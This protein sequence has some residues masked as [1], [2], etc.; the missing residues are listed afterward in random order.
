[1]DIFSNLTPKQALFCHEYF[2]DFN[3]T[4]AA[5]RAGY[6][7]AT[8]L[9]GHLMTL[10]KI[11]FHLQQRG[12]EA[13]ERAQVTHQMVLA[14]L[15]KVAF[16]GMGDFFDDNGNLLPMHKVKAEA[17]SAV[18][19]YTVTEAK[20]GTTTIKIRMNNKLSA[21]DKIAKHLKFY[22]AEAPTN[23]VNYWIQEQP[24]LDVDD[25][26]DDD[27]FAKR[28]T[29]QEAEL[30]RRVAE[31]TQQAIA[32]TERRMKKHFAAKL[33][34]AKNASQKKQKNT[35]KYPP[36]C[37][38]GEHKQAV[39]DIIINPVVATEKGN[40]DETGNDGMEITKPLTD[41]TNN[42]AAENEAKQIGQQQS[43]YIPIGEPIGYRL[44]LQRNRTR[45]KQARYPGMDW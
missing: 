17:R 31:A 42:T 15:K 35:D 1:M 33:K 2:K 34:E 45:M 39:E 21:L 5:L 43:G 23:D 37:D 30:N 6:S 10:P 25:R 22:D 4:K 32:E 41:E 36:V 9:N 11:K 26:Y 8:A 7:E 3:A 28:E 12:A 14:E 29:A 16:A 19:N 13:A 20:D 18:L 27:S 40:D 44:E 24:G 38:G